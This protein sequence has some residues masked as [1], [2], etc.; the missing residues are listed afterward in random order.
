MLTW[1]ELPTK[2]VLGLIPA[3][4]ADGPRYNLYSLI[5]RT[6]DAPTFVKFGDAFEQFMQD[7]PLANGSA[8][9]IETFAVQGVM[10]LPDDYSAFP[11]RHNFRN[12]VES[13]ARYT[14]DS[15]ADAV[16][17]F[18]RGWRDRFAKP[19]VSGYDK[20]QIYQN[21]GHGDEPVSAVY[22]Y[23]EWRHQRLTKL[24]NTYDPHG[25]FN[26]YHPVPSKLANWS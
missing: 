21:Y 15:V 7:Y 14:D 26:G 22:G 17:D 16:N 20:L 18:F 23:E 19:A 5:S 2:S 11:H 13:V 4:C 6:L 8:L 12:Q 3:S 9:Q 1:A 24:K 10:A 25:F